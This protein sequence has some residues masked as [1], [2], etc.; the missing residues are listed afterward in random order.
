[1][2]LGPQNSP[3]ARDISDLLP[4]VH[5]LDSPKV[6]PMHYAE[7]NPEEWPGAEELVRLTAS[8]P[9]SRPLLNADAPTLVHGLPFG[10]LRHGGP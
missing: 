1:M 9:N 8:F 7:Q 5:I 6:K 4:G 3:S 2:A 10:N